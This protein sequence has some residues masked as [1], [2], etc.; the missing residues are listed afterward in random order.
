M[1]ELAPFKGAPP[2]RPDW[3]EEAVNEPFETLRV[4]FDGVDIEV[5]AWGEVGKPGLMLLHG[6]FA[7]AHWW[8][9]LAARLSD[10]FRVVAPSWS[11]MGGSG[12]RESYSVSNLADEAIAAGEAGGLFEGGPPV[13]AGHSFGGGPTSVA[14]MRYGDRLSGVIILDTF[15]SDKPSPSDPHV[16]ARRVFN[17][18]E[19]V[20]ARFRLLP[21]E[22]C[23]NLFYLDYVARHSLRPL[24]ADDPD[25]PGFIW[26]TDPDMWTSIEWFDRLSALKAAKC[27]I[28]FID[29]GESRISKENERDEIKPLLAPGTRYEQI[30]GASHH[31]MLHKPLE[32]ADRI[33]EIAEW[34]QQA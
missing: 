27:K 9:P 33:R 14:A 29:G 24:P 21:T 7:H 8:T 10:H 6:G 22:P 2:P 3:F 30:A 20:L 28:A 34:M 16:Q 18:V 1:Y 5:L 4:P 25:A 13:I 32:L 12:W 11:G 15:V 31:I 19:E 23:E 26:R 17:S